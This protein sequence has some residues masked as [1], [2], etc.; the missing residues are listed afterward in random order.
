MLWI[1]YNEYV[2][3]LVRD[4]SEPTFNE[5]HDAPW[6]TPPPLCQQIT[7]QSAHDDCRQDKLIT[8]APPLRR[9][10]CYRRLQLL[11]PFYLIVKDKRKSEK[12]KWSTENMKRAVKAIM[13]GKMGYLET[14]ITFDVPSST[15]E[16]YFKKER[17]KEDSN[18][19]NTTITE[20]SQIQSVE[21]DPV[22]IEENCHA[23]DFDIH[24]LGLEANDGNDMQLPLVE[25]TN[26]MVQSFKA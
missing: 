20:L 12:Q 24:A 10:T 26:K 18:L 8:Y 15:L 7:P 17:E 16:K 5:Y 21:S 11:A 25:V 4:S 22:T 14:W 13:K 2:L 9:T 1:L 3:S 23:Q 19:H 6:L